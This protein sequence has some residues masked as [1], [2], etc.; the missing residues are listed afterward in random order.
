MDNVLCGANADS[1]KYYFNEE[2][3]GS[4]PQAVK[5][6]LKILLVKFLSDVGGAATLSFDES[7]NLLITTYEPVDEIGAELL[8]KKLQEE[9]L[10]LFSQLELYHRTFFP[11]SV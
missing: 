7:H 3:F 9:N 1:M 11:D 6:E 2:K 8:V 10:E 4:L 5:D